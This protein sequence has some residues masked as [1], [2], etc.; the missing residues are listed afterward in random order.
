MRALVNRSVAV[1]DA[2]GC[3][4]CQPLPS[5]IS[6]QSLEYRPCPLHDDALRAIQA[7]HNVYGADGRVLEERLEKAHS[8]SLRTAQDAVTA[9]FNAYRRGLRLR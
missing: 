2:C 5:P 4:M 7:G 3:E 6:Q 1:R 8:V 9:A